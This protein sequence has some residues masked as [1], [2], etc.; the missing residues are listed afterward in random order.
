[1]NPINSNVGVDPCV[2]PNKNIK[3]AGI[4]TFITEKIKYIDNLINGR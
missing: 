2:N 4:F 1:M 3:R